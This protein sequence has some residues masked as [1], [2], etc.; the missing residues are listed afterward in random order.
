MTQI[1]INIPDSLATLA[2][3][4][5]QI[6]TILLG[7]A[8]WAAIL[9]VMGVVANVC[10]AIDKRGRGVAPP[11]R[12]PSW[13]P[14]KKWGAG[15]VVFAAMALFVVDPFIAALSALLQR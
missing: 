12:A 9:M 14:V 10:A 6:E 15:L 4:S 2:P 5:Q 3:S 7:V 11:Y 8:L 13:T 1:V